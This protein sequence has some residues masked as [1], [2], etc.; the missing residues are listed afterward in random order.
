MEELKGYLIFVGCGM[1]LLTVL[2]LIGLVGMVKVLHVLLD[3]DDSRL[4]FK[5]DASTERELEV[6]RVHYKCPTKGHVL[7][8]AIA[9]LKVAQQHEQSDGSVVMKDKQSQ[10]TIVHMYG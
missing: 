2:V 6:L 8:K 3:A 1:L 4:S 5:V 7:R 9:I 10:D